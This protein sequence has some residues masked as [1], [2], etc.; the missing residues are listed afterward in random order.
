MVLSET[1]R[2]LGQ[3]ANNLTARTAKA[4]TLYT[5]YMLRMA[6]SEANRAPG[7]AG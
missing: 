5:L 1:N 6:L 2:A 7:A 3:Q 4:E